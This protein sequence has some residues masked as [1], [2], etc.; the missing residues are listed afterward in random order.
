MTGAS[1]CVCT[2]TAGPPCC[3]PAAQARWRPPWFPCCLPPVP[4]PALALVLGLARTQP[5]CSAN[6]PPW[7]SWGTPPPARPALQQRA[8]ALAARVPVLPL[9]VRG[10]RA[11]VSAALVDSRRDGFGLLVLDDA[12]LL[13]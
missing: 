12:W 3:K 1:R 13:R 10:L 9:Y 5:C 7:G 6:C 2:P 4:A 8:L 11:G